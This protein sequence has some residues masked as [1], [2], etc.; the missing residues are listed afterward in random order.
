MTTSNVDHV[1]NVC[2]RLC[3]IRESKLPECLRTGC[4]TGFGAANIDTTFTSQNKLSE[5]T[6]TATA[7][8]GHGAGSGLI[9]MM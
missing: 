6:A 3:E 8:A 9:A 1:V 4:I 2:W 7:T 5:S